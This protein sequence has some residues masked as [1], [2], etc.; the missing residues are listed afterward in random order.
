MPSKYHRNVKLKKYPK[1]LEFITAPERYTV[2]EATTK[3]G[4]TAGCLVWLY[5]QAVKG[6]PGQTFWWLS[7]IREMAEKAF[8]RMRQKISDPACFKA[9][10]SDLTLTLQNGAVIY[11]RSAFNP[12]YLFG[13]DAWAVVIDEATRM[14]EEVWFA[15]R[16]VIT[17]T[18][19]P[20]K[21]IG[22]VKGTNNWVY[23]LAR[24][25][26][27]GDKKDWK[28]LKIT[29]DDAVTAGVIEQEEIDDAKACLPTG[30]FLELYYG[31]PNQSSSNKFC[32]AFDDKKHVGK[33]KVV[34]MPIYLS[35]DFN[36]NPI[37]CTVFQL[38]H[39][40]LWVPLCIKL[41]NS[42]IFEL[43]RVIRTKFPHA[44]FRVTGDASGQ[45]GSAYTEDTWRYYNIIEN[46]LKVNSQDF[47]IPTSN[48][49]LNK[50]QVLVNAVLEHYKVQI[51]PDNAMDLIMDLK[52]VEMKPNG[53]I[54]KDSRNRFSQ[55]ADLLD[56]FRY[57]CN[58]YM[59][60]QYPIN[61]FI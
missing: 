28:Y 34:N 49:P 58:A 1:Q 4:K 46:R 10:K 45:S 50:N 17:K 52:F 37:C 54:N 27:K 12:D 47:D 23:K 19:G 21:I 33:C 38:Y 29:A 41:K 40:T 13:E 25:A 36:H 35:F 60:D 51:D 59:V 57:F 24:E 42:N 2:I 15:V 14:K 26:E 9:N 20:V 32:Y 55:Q 61:H 30:V 6:K 11:F 5:E 7:P 8:I 43:C 16:S 53:T 18:R 48:P 56:T 39:D 31:I 44:S 3:A 22:N